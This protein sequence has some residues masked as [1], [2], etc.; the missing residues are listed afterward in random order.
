MLSQ[1]SVPRCIRRSA[2]QR[3]GYSRGS[4]QEA[5]VVVDGGDPRA[6]A[7]A[8]VAA[9]KMRPWADARPRLAARRAVSAERAAAHSTQ[10][11]PEMRL[12]P[13]IAPGGGSGG[14]GRCTVARIA[15]IIA[16]HIAP[17]PQPMPTP[18]HA[19]SVGGVESGCHRVPSCTQ[20]RSFPRVRLAISSRPADTDAR[21][22]GL[23]PWAVA[24]KARAVQPNYRSFRSLTHARSHPLPQCGSGRERLPP[25]S[26]T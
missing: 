3:C 5:A 16:K 23:R 4:P 25:P 8:S 10:C 18:T 7:R 17:A 26:R 1:Q 19:H 24:H 21:R 6:A 22:S 11:A 15:T 13:R 2:R 12:E 9:S 20:A 14:P